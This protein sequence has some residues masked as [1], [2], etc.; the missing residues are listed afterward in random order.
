MQDLIGI[1]YFLCIV[2]YEFSNIWEMISLMK[3]LFYIKAF[4]KSENI[5]ILFLKKTMFIKIMF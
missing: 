5:T 1:Y 3:I 2:L 4:S